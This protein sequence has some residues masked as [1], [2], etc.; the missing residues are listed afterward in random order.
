MFGWGKGQPK[1]VDCVE[2]GFEGEVGCGGNGVQLYG[3]DEGIGNAELGPVQRRRRMR[4][5]FRAG[6]MVAGG[7]GFRGNGIA[8]VFPRGLFLLFAEPLS[9]VGLRVERRG[10]WL[11]SG[12]GGDAAGNQ[13]FD[14]YDQ[15]NGL[16]LAGDVAPGYFVA[17]R[18][19]FP[20]PGEDLVAT[21]VEFA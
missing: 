16:D 15:G 1:G 13:S 12:W 8:W 9:A 7:S 2:N 10:R 11:R 4:C 21:K 19:E 5:I 14:G 6:A 3:V 18:G 20:E 17:E